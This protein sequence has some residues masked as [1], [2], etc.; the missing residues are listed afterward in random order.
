VPKHLKDASYE[1]AKKLGHGTGYEY[2]HN[3][4][5]GYVEQVYLTEKRVYYEPVERGFEAEILKRMKQLRPDKSS[6]SELKN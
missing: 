6:E 3:H 4:E 1:G 2:S 5:S